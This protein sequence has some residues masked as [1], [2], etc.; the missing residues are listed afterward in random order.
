MS[1]QKIGDVVGLLYLAQT[2]WTQ[3]DRLIYNLRFESVPVV[4]RASHHTRQPTW[5][6][7]STFSLR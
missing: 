2:H 3:N 1:I 6:S 4:N 7:K 5:R